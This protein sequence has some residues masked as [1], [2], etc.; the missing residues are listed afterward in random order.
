M[1]ALV[2]GVLAGGIMTGYV[3]YKLLN[4]IR[5]KKQVAPALPDSYF[6]RELEGCKFKSRGRKWSIGD[7]CRYLP[8]K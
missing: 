2:A 5:G 8:S 4:C 6:E 7:N 1:A 3:L